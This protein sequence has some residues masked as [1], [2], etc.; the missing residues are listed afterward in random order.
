MILA[1]IGAERVPLIS[2]DVTVETAGELVS[3][4]VLRALG[5]G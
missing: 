5:N 1:V 4:F 2:G 3:E